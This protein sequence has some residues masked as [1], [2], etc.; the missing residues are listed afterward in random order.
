MVLRPGEECLDSVTRKAE[1]GL[2][3]IISS[4]RIYSMLE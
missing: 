2:V 4:I 1:T 3:T